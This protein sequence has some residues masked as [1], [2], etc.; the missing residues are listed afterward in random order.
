LLHDI[1]KVALDS[2]LGERYQAVDERV[3]NEDYAFL[4]AEQEM[5]GYDY[6]EVGALMIKNWNMSP[7]LRA[8]TI[9]PPTHGVCGKPNVVCDSQPGQ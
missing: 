6:M 2:N 7:A 5:L 4:E 3:Y 8:G 1:G 9:A